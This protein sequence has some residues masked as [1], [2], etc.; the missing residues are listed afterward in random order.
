MKPKKKISR[1]R[2]LL[3]VTYKSEVRSSDDWFFLFKR[4][5]SVILSPHNMTDIL[6]NS[7]SNHE[8]KRWFTFTI[9]AQIG[10]TFFN[11]FKTRKYLNINFFIKCPSFLKGIKWR[12]FSDGCVDIV[13]ETKKSIKETSLTVC[14]IQE[15]SMIVRR[16]IF[17][18]QKKNVRDFVTPQYD[19][20]FAQIQF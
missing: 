9:L 5:M 17:Y 4:K 10:I 2:P 13:V 6:R 3:S 19:G 18:L 16:L 1:K 7:N 8:K 15:W 14:D 12:T 11:G 20:H